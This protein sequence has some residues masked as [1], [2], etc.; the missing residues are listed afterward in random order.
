MVLPTTKDLGVVPESDGYVVVDCFG[1]ERP[2]N[3]ALLATGILATGVET[4]DAYGIALDVHHHLNEHHITRIDSA[5]L[6][7]LTA[8]R[9]SDKLSRSLAERYLRW[10]RARRFGRPLVVLLAGTC[11][12]GKSTLATQLAIRLGIN[13]VVSTDTIRE[14][15]RTTTPVED[16]P[17]LHQSILDAG[18]SQAVT[19]AR[20]AQVVTSACV[21]VARRCLRDNKSVLFEGSHLFPGDLAKALRG[22]DKNPIVIERMLYLNDTDMASRRGESAND[23]APVNRPGRP[24]RAAAALTLQRTMRDMAAQAGVRDFAIEGG[25]DLTR[26][27]VDEYVDGSLD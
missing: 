25:E 19:Y 12:I 9:I 22:H 27:V 10:N 16:A 18:P 1:A 3:K 24:D 8:N 7:V 23:E 15:L 11:G 4:P 14:V 13:Q 5:D 6:V 21:A 26:H 17:E 2:F 20:Q